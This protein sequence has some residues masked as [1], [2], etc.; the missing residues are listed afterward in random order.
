MLDLLIGAGSLA[1]LCSLWVLWQRFADRVEPGSCSDRR[2]GGGCCVPTD[3]KSHSCSE[4]NDC[5]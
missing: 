4:C 1:L 2:A 5:A 3:P